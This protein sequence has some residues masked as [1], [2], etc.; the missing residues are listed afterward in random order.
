MDNAEAIK[1]CGGLFEGAI[2]YTISP[3]HTLDSY[4][5]YGQ[6]LKDLGADYH[7]PSRTWPACSRPI[8][9]SAW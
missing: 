6:Q 5:E 1:E 4:L 8:A 7:L 3:V 2:S 9:P